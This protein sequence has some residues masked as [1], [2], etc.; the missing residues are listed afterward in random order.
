[1][2]LNSLLH[3]VLLR[4]FRLLTCREVE[5]LSY[6]FLDGNLDRKL[7]RR[8]DRHLLSCPR[9]HRF[10]NSYRK[11]KELG[12]NLPVPPLDPKF[13]DEMLAFLLRERLR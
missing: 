10:M 13:K 4:L 1:M 5:Q 9:C 8:I 3:S 11:T 6:D 7:A 12:K 2:R